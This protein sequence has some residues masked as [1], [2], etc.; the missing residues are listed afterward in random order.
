IAMVRH[1]SVLQ[2]DDRAYAAFPDG[3]PAGTSFGEFLGRQ[4]ESFLGALGFDYLWL[5][6]GF[7]FSSYAWSELGESFD[8]ER[9]RSERTGELRSRALEFWRDLA[10]HLHHPV[11]VRGTN[12]TAG[13]DIGADSVPA[14]EVYEAGYI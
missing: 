3:I 10:A 9:F 7:G 2:P 11:Q 1:F 8:G 14:L 12:H 6:N 5:S 13:I 4:A